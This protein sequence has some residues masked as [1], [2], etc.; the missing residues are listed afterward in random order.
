MNR[1]QYL[2]S[3]LKPTS[4]PKPLPTWCHRIGRPANANAGAAAAAAE[5]GTTEEQQQ[6]ASE[7]EEE[8][9]QAF[10]DKL[11]H[12]DWERLEKEPPE[13]LFGDNDVWV[14]ERAAKL[15]A[16]QE[17][18]DR[19]GAMTK[20]TTT[21]TTTTTTATADTNPPVGGGASSD[22]NSAA[23]GLGK[24]AAEVGG[25]AGGEKA[26]TGG[27]G[28]GGGGGDGVGGEKKGKPSLKGASRLVANSNMATKKTSKGEV[29]PSG[30]QAR[31]AKVTPSK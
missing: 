31:T 18:R 7:Q 24:A 14:T 1:R 4:G 6:L 10:L 12:D 29:K 13:G 2:L 16:R 15:L 9:Q 27:G 22:T 30:R 3:R 28:E 19:E 8:E 11:S 5:E 21:T 23:T 26:A 20:T 25:L 17:E